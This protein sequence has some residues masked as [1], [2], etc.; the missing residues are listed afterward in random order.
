MDT[1]PSFPSISEIFGRG[2]LEKMAELTFDKSLL[3]S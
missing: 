3:L 2:C 1:G